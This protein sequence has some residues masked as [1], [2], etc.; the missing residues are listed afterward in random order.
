M[1]NN[2]PHTIS[3][4]HKTAI[5]E[6]ANIWT[7]RIASTITSK[8]PSDSFCQNFPAHGFILATHPACRPSP[9]APVLACR[10]P[11]PFHRPPFAVA[12][13]CAAAREPSVAARQ[14]PLAPVCRRQ[15]ADCRLPFVTGNNGKKELR[16]RACSFK[17]APKDRK[18]RYAIT[19]IKAQV[20]A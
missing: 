19:S 16:F 12:R 20:Y 13:L 9:P 2:A 7:P 1:T 5:F 14:P 18:R 3:Q 10:R 17:H 15:N 6:C 4:C 11:P 8:I